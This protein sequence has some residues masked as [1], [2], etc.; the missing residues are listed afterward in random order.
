MPGLAA[1]LRAQ[2]EGE[3]A[4]SIPLLFARH[5]QPTYDY[6][7]I[8]LASKAHVASM[9]TAAAFQQILEFRVGEGR[10]WGGG[11]T[12]GAELPLRARVDG[13]AAANDMLMQFQAD[14]LGVPV[15]RP[16]TL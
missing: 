11:V 5:W 14:L 2:P 15:L 1:L 9:V 3:L 7:V 8:C 12:A 13:G 6:S 16:Q 10:V 4:Q